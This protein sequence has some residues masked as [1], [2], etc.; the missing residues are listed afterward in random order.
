MKFLYI[1]WMI[2]KQNSASS[3][4]I[5]PRIIPGSRSVL[6]Q[7]RH[8]TEMT[9]LP[10]SASSHSR[11]WNIVRRCL[12]AIAV[13]ET[14]STATG[15]S[16]SSS[17]IACSQFSGGSIVPS[18]SFRGRRTGWRVSGHCGALQ[19]IL[20]QFRVTDSQFTAPLSGIFLATGCLINWL[21][22]LKINVFC[23]KLFGWRCGFC[24]SVLGSNQIII[25]IYIYIYINQREP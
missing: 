4:I 18:S 11:I 17:A 12:V 13:V 6:D 7:F 14:S 3:A 20:P 9:F 15:I 23:G 24:E 25:Y 16:S 8:K 2:H 19:V 5:S 10:L 22:E 1:L 21:R